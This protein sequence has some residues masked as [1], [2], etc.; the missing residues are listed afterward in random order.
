MQDLLDLFYNDINKAITEYENNIVQK[1][2]ISKTGPIEEIPIN[3]AKGE[4]NAATRIKGLVASLYK[5]RKTD[6]SNNS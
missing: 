3:L 6:L 5:K 2:F 1:N 4:L